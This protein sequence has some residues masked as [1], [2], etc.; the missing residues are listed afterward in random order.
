MG[1]VRPGSAWLGFA[2]LHACHAP[3]FLIA[4]RSLLP[5]LLRRFTGCSDLQKRGKP[6][7]SSSR[8][9][10][11]MYYS[12]TFLS[13]VVHLVDYTYALTSYQV[14]PTVEITT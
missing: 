9:A 10:F 8:A 14:C 3:A 11:Y 13:L 6:A 12:A 1:S 2:L 4:P 5:F 7:F